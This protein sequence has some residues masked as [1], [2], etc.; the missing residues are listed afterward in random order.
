MSRYICLAALN[1]NISNI[2][3]VPE[4]LFTDDF[5][6]EVRSIMDKINVDNSVDNGVDNSL[7]KFLSRGV[8]LKNLIEDKILLKLYA[9]R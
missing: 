9:S 5:A 2:K 6:I 4:D 1:K 3:Y 7:N 8:Q